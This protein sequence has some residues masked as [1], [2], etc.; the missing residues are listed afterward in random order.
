MPSLAHYKRP[1]SL[2]DPRPHL[3]LQLVVVSLRRSPQPD[4]LVELRLLRGPLLRPAFV[5]NQQE[6][7]LRIL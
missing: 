1:G 7:M 3:R 4:S 2:V 6:P 5:P